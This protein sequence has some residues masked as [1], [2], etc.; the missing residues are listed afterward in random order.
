M[1]NNSPSSDQFIKFMIG[2]T[3]Y[4]AGLESVFEIIRVPIIT[5]IPMAPHYV[6]GVINLRG[7]IIPV[8]GARSKMGLTTSEITRETV[9]I[10]ANTSHG[11][12]GVLV[13][14]VDEVIKIASEKIQAPV[15]IRESDDQ[16]II[17]IAN[18]QDSSA[19]L[20]DIC[21]FAQIQ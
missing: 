21:R 4:G 3:S 10:I 11:L 13:D 7:K 16:A 20:V 17:G 6:L 9:I 14:K 5:P 12:V 15:T 18:T 2:D 19:V 1:E 8:I